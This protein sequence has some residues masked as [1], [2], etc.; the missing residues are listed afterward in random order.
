M[1]AT[2]DPDKWFLRRWADWLY[3]V[4]GSLSDNP[5]KASVKVGDYEP[6]TTQDPYASL[7]AYRARPLNGIWATAPYLH[8]G[9]VPTL[10]DLLLPIKKE[11]DPEDGKYRPE[12]FMVGS[13]EFDPVKVGF[14]TE[15][16]DGH[17][18]TTFRIGDLN[19]G[20][21][22]AAGNTKVSP[23]DEEPLPALTETERWELLEFL[24]TL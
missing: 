7:N 9:S 24:K 17:K 20:H 23:D 15:G 19:S 1:V 4:V 3:V 12:S 22:Y 18:F 10:Y 11:G 5:I 6:D 8:N 2:P 14:R 21:E 16:Y 13:R